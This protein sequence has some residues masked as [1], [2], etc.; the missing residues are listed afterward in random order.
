MGSAV[1]AVTK[2][3]RKVFGNEIGGAIGGTLIGGPFGALIGYQGGAAEEAEEK[4]KK[5][6]REAEAEQNAADREAELLRKN[7]L[8]TDQR[9]ST[10][11]SAYQDIKNSRAAASGAGTSAGKGLSG[12]DDEETLGG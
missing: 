10:A 2:P 7:A 9:A 1:N 3:F 4:Q 11:A 12:S 5:A 6:Q 8:L